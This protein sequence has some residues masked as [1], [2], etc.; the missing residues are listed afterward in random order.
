MNWAIAFIML[1]WMVR[2]M[3]RS[4]GNVLLLLDLISIDMAEIQN[5]NLPLLLGYQN[6]L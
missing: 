6:Q 5:L 2:T 4:I 3:Y 1:Y